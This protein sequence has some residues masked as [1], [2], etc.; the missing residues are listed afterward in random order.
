MIT[1]RLSVKIVLVLIVLFF[2][3][4]PVAAY[5]DEAIN[6]YNQ[7]NTFT[8]EGNYTE[9]VAAYNNAI[10][11]A[12]DYYE[13][14][15]GMADVLNR[16]GQFSEALAA[17]NQSLELNSSY[18]AGWINRGYILYNI[19]NYYENQLNDTQTADEL[20]N[21]QLQAF[22]NAIAA[23]PKDADAWFNKA[24]ALGGL[25]RYDE[26]IAAF[27][28]VKALD[29]DYPNLAENREIAVELRNAAEPW[30]IKYAFPLVIGVIVCAGII[31]WYITTRKKRS[32]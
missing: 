5:S 9:A 10:T 17:S 18:A 21:Q 27:D 12:P 4:V 31:G 8:S 26:A 19:G 3:S 30:Y 16:A 28:Q 15:N 22:D 14:W 20:Y 13:A 7:G 6:S 11:L 23:D 32:A 24:Y 2:L 1:K 25:E 29:P